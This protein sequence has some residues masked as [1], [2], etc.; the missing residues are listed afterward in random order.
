MKK[1]GIKSLFVMLCFSISMIVATKVAIKI[2]SKAIVW[3]IEIE[4]ELLEKEGIFDAETE[5]MLFDSSIYGYYGKQLGDTEKTVY[6][7]IYQNAVTFSNKNIISDQET[8]YKAFYALVFD[9]PELF[10]LEDVFEIR[11]KNNNQ[12]IKLKYTLPIRQVKEIQTEIDSITNKILLEVEGMN[13]YEKELYIHNYLL[14][15]VKYSI[16]A[17]AQANVYGALVQNSTNCRGFSAAFQYLL[18]KCGVPTGQVIGDIRDNDTL[19]GHSWNFV[20]LDGEPY[21]VDVLWDKVDVKSLGDYHYAFFNTTLEFMD[22]THDR[23]RQLQYLSDTEE[24]SGRYSYYGQNGM[25]AQSYEEACDIIMDK[26]PMAIAA[27][28]RS[29]AIQVLDD[30]DFSKLMTNIRAI[31]EKT[32]IENGLNMEQCDIVKI[33]NG[34]TVILRDFKLQKG[35]IN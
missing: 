32:I 21:Y 23:T 8:F 20:M 9:H 24:N 14:T 18:E 16:S 4:A 5:S 19:I 12:K 27:G 2:V 34:N 1:Y 13:D 29:F 33:K 22:R 30:E 6:A 25:M 35:L 3:K 17:S 7:D 15:N 26:L 11:V 28:K 31:V 10:Y